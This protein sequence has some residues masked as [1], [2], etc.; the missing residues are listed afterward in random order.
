MK[1]QP[2]PYEDIVNRPRPVSETR[3]RMPRADRAAQF[4]P[5]AALSGFGAAIDETARLTEERLELSESG[6]AEL[7]AALRA[8]RERIGECPAAELT[9][10]VPDERKAGGAY[11]TARARVRRIDLTERTLLLADGR[12][13]PLDALY[14]LRPLTPEEVETDAR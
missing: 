8:L 4:S 13:V 6:A 3:P 5:F 10:F 14:A 12:R 7:D 2:F 11:V 9:W 1:E